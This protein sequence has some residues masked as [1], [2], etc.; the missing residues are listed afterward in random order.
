MEVVYSGPVLKGLGAV[1]AG[2]G[3]CGAPLGGGSAGSDT[4]GSLLGA[5]GVILE[6]GHRFET[7]PWNRNVPFNSRGNSLLQTE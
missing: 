4:V 7:G 1:E 5:F 6:P 2:S 3:R